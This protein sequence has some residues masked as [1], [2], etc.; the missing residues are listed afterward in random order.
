M[1]EVSMMEANMA[2]TTAQHS[3]RTYRPRLS[4]RGILGF[5]AEADA[6]HRA[7][8]QLHLLDDHLLRDMG[9]NRADRDAEVR[10]TF[11]W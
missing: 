8:A 10:R 11:L 4:V 5:L 1:T 3:S 9:I 7:R 2:M 6:R